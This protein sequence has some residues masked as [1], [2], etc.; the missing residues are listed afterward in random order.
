M[1]SFVIMEEALRSMALR[2]IKRFYLES[3]VKE[4][5]IDINEAATM[6][7]EFSKK[8]DKLKI[9]YELRCC[10]CIDVLGEFD[11]LSDIKKNIEIECEECGY[12]NIINSD[13]IYIYYY[14][15]EEY[16]K[17]VIS[18]SRQKKPPIRLRTSSS[19]TPSSIKVLDEEGAFKVSNAKD[20]YN[21]EYYEIHLGDSYTNNGN[22]GSIGKESRAEDFRF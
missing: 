18:I 12:K 4:N 2:N 3:F 7:Y 20:N 21:I 5:D 6:L 22:A 19:I 8:S 1:R 11:N 17:E 14:I 10:N 15:S 13:N 16:R 9:K